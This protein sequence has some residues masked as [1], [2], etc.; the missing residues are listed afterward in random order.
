MWGG[1][2][3]VEVVFDF[4]YIKFCV[5]DNKEKMNVILGGCE[6]IKKLFV[7]IVVDFLF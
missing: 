2:Y 4:N 3:F 6:K 1:C 5:V 7:R